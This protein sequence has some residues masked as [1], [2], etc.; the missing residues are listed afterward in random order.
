MKKTFTK[1]PSNYV[2]AS[3]EEI[4]LTSAEQKQLKDKLYQI[5]DAKA[6]YHEDLIPKKS[7]GLA[8]LMELYFYWGDEYN[9]GYLGYDE[10]TCEDKFDKYLLQEFK[11]YRG[12]YDDDDV[13]ACGD[14]KAS[15]IQAA[16][17]KK[18]DMLDVV[19]EQQDALE[20]DFGYALA[21]IEKLCRDGDCQ[22]ALEIIN[23]L[24][25]AINQE[26]SAI[27]G[28]IGGEAIPEE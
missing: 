24:S 21:G 8:D 25:D 28:N 9:D 13:E 4:T 5:V 18:P 12:E 20:D 23:R 16:D 22:K 17:G 3:T 26:I 2:K 14:V 1:Y 11:K 27:S 6:E 7:M 19:E 15:T 10:S